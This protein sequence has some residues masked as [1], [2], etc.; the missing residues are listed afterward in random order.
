VE[1]RVLNIDDVELTPRPPLF[2]AKGEAAQRFESRTGAIGTRLGAQK[3]GYNICVVPPGKRAFP[4]HNHHVNEEMFFILEGCGELR[5]GAETVPL[6]QGDFIACPPGGPDS[7][8]QIVNT[9]TAELRYLAVS[10]RQYPELVEYPD[11]GKFAT[12]HERGR[13]PDGA[14]LMFRYFGREQDSLDYWDGE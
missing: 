1:P 11:S 10:T 6:R 9:G 2:I 3:L 14:P 13:L 7:A 5:W 8:H 4:L 12:L